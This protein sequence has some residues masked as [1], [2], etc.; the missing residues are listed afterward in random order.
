MSMK[1]KYKDKEVLSPGTVIISAVGHTEDID[2]IIQPFIYTDS[3]YIYK[4]DFSSDSLKLGGS[5]LYQSQN[6]VGTTAPDI[7]DSNT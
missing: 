3:G 2:K 1:Q 5:A 4:I 7:K 6:K